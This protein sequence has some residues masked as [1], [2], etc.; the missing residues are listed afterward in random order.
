MILLS[1]VVGAFFGAFGMLVALALMDDI[2]QKK[3]G[4]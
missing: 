4:E 2:E 1:F 3:K